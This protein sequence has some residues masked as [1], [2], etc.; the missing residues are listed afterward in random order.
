MWN[1][2]S[3]KEKMKRKKAEPLMANKR[4]TRGYLTA[5]K[6]RCTQMEEKNGGWLDHGMHCVKKPEFYP[7]IS[8]DDKGI[9]T[10]KNCMCVESPSF[11]IC[12]NP[13]VIC[14]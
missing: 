5:D 4:K 2:W 10:E 3:W 1:W 7:Q 6:R 13:F 12:V 9:R 8:R 14:G 11:L